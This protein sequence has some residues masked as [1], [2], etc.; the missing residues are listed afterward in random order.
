MST[1]KVLNHYIDPLFKSSSIS[2]AYTGCKMMRFRSGRNMDNTGVDAV[3]SYK[4]ND[5][6]ATFDRE[7]IYHELSTM[8]NGVTTLGHYSLERNSLYVNGLELAI[9]A[10]THK[11]PLKS[12]KENFRLS[13]RISNLPYSPELQD[14][15]SQM[16]RQN[17]EKIE[18]ELDVFRT[19][20][21]KDYFAGCTVENFGPV[22]GKAYTSVTSTC[23]FLLDPFSRVLQKQEVYEELK[24][25][26]HGF[27]KLGSSYE[28]EEQSLVVEGYSPVKTD[29][30]ESEKSGKC[31]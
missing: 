26:T 15:R 24:R 5:S 1:V 6:L 2:S 25:L 28:L 17:K 12:G 18:K 16:Y 19:S 7:K 13:F 20:R 31:F 4:T 30:Q 8:T 27:T 23:K 14:S 10:V 29:E 9:E 3:C 11:A 22:R 21:L